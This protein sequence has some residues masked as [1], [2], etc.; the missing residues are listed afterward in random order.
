VSLLCPFCVPSSGTLADA[1]EAA[2]AGADIVMLDNFE[3]AALKVAAAEIKAAYP[4]VLIEAR[5]GM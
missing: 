5:Y 4:A 1:H 3:P 2:T